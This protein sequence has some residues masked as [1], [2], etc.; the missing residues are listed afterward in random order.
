[1][2]QIRSTS[3]AVRGAAPYRAEVTAIGGRAG[4]A[5]SS[6]RRLRLELGGPSPRPCG[7]SAAGEG[8]DP[9]Q[10]LAAAYA[11]CFL[12]AIRAAGEEAGIAIAPDANVTARI[13]HDEP[14]PFALGVTLGVTLL[15]DLPGVGSAQRQSL[16]ER[17]HAISMCSRA[18]RCGVT[19]RTITD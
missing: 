1:V 10:L 18:L 2:A 6:D 17:A 12:S 7:R 11:A 15:V 4:F 19:V 16:V 14:D 9:E 5:Q 8:T 13:E 3:D